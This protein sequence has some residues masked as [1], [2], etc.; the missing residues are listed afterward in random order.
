MPRRADVH[1]A[2]LVRRRQR[3]FSLLEMLVALAI[4]ALAVL[5]L[6]NLAGENTRTA[7]VI[8]ERV[9]AGVVAE[10]RAVEAMVANPAELAAMA[11]ATEGNETAG[12]LRWRWKREL[13]PTD[14]PGLVRVDITVMP[15]D[16]E[17]IAAEL[18][19]FRSVPR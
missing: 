9:L 19:L 13:S 1:W 12:N 15:V 16:E 5:G 8:E 17:R 14:D 4:F 3:G 11:S 2:G 10:N 7:V 6:L 18:S